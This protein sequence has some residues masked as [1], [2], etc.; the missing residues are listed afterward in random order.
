MSENTLGAFMEEE[1]VSQPEVWQRAVE[2]AR[3]EQLLPADGKRIAVIGCGTSWFMAQ[4]YA[5]A[6]ESAG[7]GVT[8]AFAASE[9]FLNSNSADRQYD[10]VVAIT[11]SGTTTEVLEVLAQLKGIVP[12]IAI[13]GDTSSPIVELADVVVG[14]PYADERSV[15]Q[16]RFATTA[17][18]Y[19]LTTLGVDVQQAIEDARGAVTAPVSGELLDAEQFTFLGTG[20]TIGLAHEA[21]LKMREAVQGWTESYPAKEYRHGPISIAA[22]GRVTWLF[23]TQPEGLDTDMA[24]TGAL[25]IHTEKH[26]LAELARVHKVTLER[27]RVRGLNP[28]LPRNLTRSVILDASA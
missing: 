8:D 5:A 28:D 3:A 24:V 26:P 16:T 17:L 6:R 2:Q 10:A 12:T 25:Y 7:K 9:A 13:I 11:R 19:M 23:G 15:V 21:G 27:A 22:P 18:V 14:L 4:S 1:L 20:W